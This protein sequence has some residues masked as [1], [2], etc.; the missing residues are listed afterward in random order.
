VLNVDRRT[1]KSI[2]AG[3][4]D[5]QPT[6]LLERWRATTLGR[7]APGLAHEINNPLSAILGTVEFLLEDAEPGSELHERLVRI[8]R[9]G[10]EIRETVRAV[11]DFAREPELERRS[12][13]LSGLCAEAVRLARR[14]SLVKGVELV[15]RYPDAPVVVEASADLVA[16][17]VLALVTNAQQVQ[18]DGGRVVVEVGVSD[19]WALVRVG[20]G[21]GLDEEL[22][23]GRELA[24]L[25]GGDLVESGPDVVLRLPAVR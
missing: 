9:S 6:R 16:Q 18:T 21:A 4:D 2:P 3:P 14:G 15:E 5:E 1:D 24:A 10:G 12:L 23:L 19:S 13:D 11:A 17:I 25:Q 20:G 22:A 7:L 8:Q